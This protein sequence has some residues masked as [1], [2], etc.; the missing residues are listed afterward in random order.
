MPQTGKQPETWKKKKNLTVIF[1]GSKIWS[2]SSTP[3]RSF[4]AATPEQEIKQ[5]KGSLHYMKSKLNK[6]NAIYRKSS[7]L[8]SDM[9]RSSSRNGRWNMGSCGGIALV[10]AA[11]RRLPQF[12]SILFLRTCLYLS[13]YALT[14]L[15]TLLAS[16]SP[17]LLW[18][19]WKSKILECCR[20]LHIF[21]LKRDKDTKHFRSGNNAALNYKQQQQPVNDVKN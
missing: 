1:L 15:A 13:T 3:Q 8:F 6:N 7:L 2:V 14:R 21:S 12:L 18:Q 10:R 16:T 17:L 5:L 11:E 4:T 9:K 20:S 19:T